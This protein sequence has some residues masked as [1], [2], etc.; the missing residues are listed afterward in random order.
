MDSPNS[1]KT[2]SADLAEQPGKRPTSGG[3]NGATRKWIFF[4]AKVLISIS[5]QSESAPTEFRKIE[6]RVLEP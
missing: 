4:F 3:N 6:L 2:P 5:I 1:S